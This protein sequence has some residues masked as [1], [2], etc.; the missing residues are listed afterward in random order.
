AA[1]PPAPFA[2]PPPPP[3][4]RE[5]LL[6]GILGAAAVSEAS[7]REPE[8][9]A[10]IALVEVAERVAVAVRDARK[11]LLVGRLDR[12]PRRHRRASGARRQADSDGIGVAHPFFYAFRTLS[13]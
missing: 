9:G 8:H 5:R 3:H 1:R 4:R 13:V 2:P 12:G 10:R 6:D 7:D 11:Q